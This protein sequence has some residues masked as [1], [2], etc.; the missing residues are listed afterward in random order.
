MKGMT[1]I[2]WHYLDFRQHDVDYTTALRAREI[3]NKCQICETHYSSSCW[4]KQLLFLECNVIEALWRKDRCL[5]NLQWSAVLS[6][7]YGSGSPL[8]LWAWGGGD[9]GLDACCRWVPS[10]AREEQHLPPQFSARCG[11]VVLTGRW[12][13]RIQVT[14][15][16]SLPGMKGNKI[17]GIYQKKPRV[18][19]RRRLY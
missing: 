11:C 3:G 4:W 5:S 16:Y 17:T 15:V 19:I 18:C 7:S 13:V 14:F 9:D 12:N 1:Y 6:W 8:M 10:H 2:F